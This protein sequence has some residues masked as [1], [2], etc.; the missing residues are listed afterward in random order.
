[1]NRELLNK[2]IDDYLTDM[3]RDPD[4]YA[5]DLRDRSVRIRYYQEWTKAR[6]LDM[7]R[8]DLDAYLGK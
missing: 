2:H 5:K 8:D 1:M 3:A 6:L 7:S 4:A